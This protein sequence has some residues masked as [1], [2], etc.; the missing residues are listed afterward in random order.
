VF[1]EGCHA[2]ALVFPHF[3]LASGARIWCLTHR[4][5]ATLSYVSELELS[6]NL[7]PRH[8]FLDEVCL[9]GVERMIRKAGSKMTRS[10]WR[11]VLIY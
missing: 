6:G 11:I 7:R 4:L 5:S 9:W 1:E 2:A 10:G 8:M 3:Q